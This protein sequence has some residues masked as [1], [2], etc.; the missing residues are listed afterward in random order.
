MKFDFNWNGR[1][2][3]WTGTAKGSLADGTEVTGT[4]S[5]GNRDWVFEASIK[6]GVMRGRH[7]EIRQGRKPYETG[8]FAIER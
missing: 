5:N 8:T 3:T 1:S 6:D 7:R 2:R 4:A